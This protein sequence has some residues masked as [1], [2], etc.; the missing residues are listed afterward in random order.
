MGD[1]SGRD[2]KNPPSRPANALAV[3]EGNGG[4]LFTVLLCCM[5]GAGAGTSP[6]SPGRRGYGA[7]P[8]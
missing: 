1:V 4:F 5:P 2:L 7:R 6:S 8:C 3:Y